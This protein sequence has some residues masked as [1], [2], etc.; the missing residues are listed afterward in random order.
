MAKLK[1]RGK[2]L[3]ALGYPQG[4]VIGL[5]INLALQAFAREKKEVVLHTLSL[6]LQEPDSFLEHPTLG[7]IA[8]E[9]KG[10]SNRAPVLRDTPLPFSVYGKENIQTEAFR[11]MNTAMQLP[12]SLAGALMPDAH[13]GYG[14]P[15]GGVLATANEVIPYGVGVDIGCRMCL[16]LFPLPPVFSEKD[17][18]R[19]VRLLQDNTVFGA[20]GELA[21][22]WDD[23]IFD[24]PEFRDI[25]QVKMLREKARRQ[26]GTSGSGNHFV[27]FGRVQIQDSA[28][29]HG[30]PPGVY[31]GL[32]SHSGSRGL[33]AGIA[34]YYT[35]LAA[36]LRELPDGVKNLAWLS[37]DEEPGMEYW[38][39]MN[40]AGDYASACH[41]HIHRRIARALGEDPLARVENHHN[42][43]WKETLPDGRR[44][45]VH[46]K[47]ATPAQKG[48]LGIIP[49]SM[50]SAG[51]IV[52]GR[53]KAE[54]L[55]SASHGA[56][57]L[58]S[59]RQAMQQ[60]NRKMLDEILRENQVTLI[61]GGI[62]EAPIAYKEIEQVMRAQEDLVDILGT[63]T[64]A[65][66][67]MDQ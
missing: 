60:I 54:S 64:P 28:H 27:E 52:V 21:K 5:T 34:T 58:M 29:G 25:P 62:D 22:P 43:A 14:L 37:L 55:Q 61:G 45:I 20:G 47:G 53:G 8:L 4:K 65:V 51:Y 56:G 36:R 24:R 10:P 42:F 16:S 9:L 7:R 40:L 31:L 66:V 2:D 39:A 11:Q 30:L 48:V 26:I 63:F 12:V 57:R 46:R 19:M 44:A 38:L 6:V 17:R 15:I 33:G 32:L 35:K 23:P 50:T 1:L 59:R 3:I 41:D 18:Q 67:R 13:S 49:G